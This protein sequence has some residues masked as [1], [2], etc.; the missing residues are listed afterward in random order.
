MPKPSCLVPCGIREDIDRG[1]TF[2]KE[3]NAYHLTW[4]GTMVVDPNKHANPFTNSTSRLP[5]RHVL[6]RYITQN[7]I[8]LSAESEL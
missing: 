2:F 6:R 7:P 1:F 8:A 5:I 3:D 4:I